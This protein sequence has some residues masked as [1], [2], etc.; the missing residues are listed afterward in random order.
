M[1]STGLRSVH[2]C[3]CTQAHFFVCS[4]SSVGAVNSLQI[5]PD[6]TIHSC[7]WS[8]VVQSRMSTAMSSSCRSDTYYIYMWAV[9]FLTVD[10]ISC[11]VS[12]SGSNRW[13]RSLLLYTNLKI[14]QA[15]GEASHACVTCP[16]PLIQTHT[17]PVSNPPLHAPYS[18]AKQPPPDPAS[19]SSHPAP[20]HSQQQ[21]HLC[22]SLP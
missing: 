15:C 3:V 14:L 21:L 9:I 8:I 18:L 22:H 5:L 20:K 2:T 6:P 19:R 7:C 16:C 12:L 1:C 4:H 17:R 11:Q 13:P 10:S